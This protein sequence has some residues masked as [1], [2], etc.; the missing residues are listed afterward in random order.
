MDSQYSDEHSIN[1]LTIHPQQVNSHL[2]LVLRI[3]RQTPV[4]PPVVE[5]WHKALRFAQYLDEH[6]INHRTLTL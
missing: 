5:Q 3:T 4:L 6:S 2:R 1:P